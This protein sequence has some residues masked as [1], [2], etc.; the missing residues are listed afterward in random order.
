MKE[1][2]GLFINYTILLDL[3]KP[4]PWWENSWA[5]LPLSHNLTI[6]LYTSEGESDNINCHSLAYLDEQEGGGVY[7]LISGKTWGLEGGERWMWISMWSDSILMRGEKWWWRTVT[8]RVGA[9]RRWK[10]INYSSTI[11]KRII[12]SHIISICNSM[13]CSAI[14]D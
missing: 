3:N 14:W 4:L 6:I 7:K 10:Y 8:R 12:N 2:L 11:P 5:H 1:V 9:A 13:A